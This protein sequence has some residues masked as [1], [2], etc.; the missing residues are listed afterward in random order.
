MSKIDDN[1]HAVLLEL[2]RNQVIRRG[3][4]SW[5]WKNKRPGLPSLNNTVTS[6]MFRCNLVEDMGNDQMTITDSGH[7]LS[8]FKQKQSAELQ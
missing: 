2:Q 1:I 5:Q 4:Y 3:K 7:I 6:R 8:H